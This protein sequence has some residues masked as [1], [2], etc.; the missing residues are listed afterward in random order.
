MATSSKSSVCSTRSGK[1]S[2][3]STSAARARARA[4]AAKVRA[5]YASQEAKL[6]M[7][8]ATREAQNQLETVRIDTE[9]EVLTL[10]R[11][12]DAAAVEA[13]VLEDAELAMHAAVERG[14]FESEK[15]KIECTSEYVNPQI[16]LQ[17]HSPSPVLS[18]LPVAPPFHADSHNSFITWSPAAKDTSHAQ[19]TKI[20]SKSEKADSMHLPATNLSD[21]SEG[22][23]KSEVGRT[24]PINNAPA[25]PY[26]AQY[27]PPASTP[28]QAEPLAQYLARR[29]LISSGLYQFDDKTENYR[30]WYSSFTSAAREVHLSATQE[31]D[32]MTKWLGKESGEMVKR[33]RS[34]H[35]SNPNLALH[36][37]W[38][39]LRECYAAPEV[40]ERSLFQR[41]DSFPRFSAKDHTKLRELRDLLMEIQG[42]KEDGYL[43]GLSYLDTSRGI[44]PVVDKLP[45]GLQDK[46]VTSG[47]WYKEGNY[48]RFPPFEYFCNFVC[49]EAKKRNYPSFMHQSSA[50]T[51][52]K[53]D[54]PIVKRFQTNKPISVH[55]TDVCA[56][57]DD[58]NKICPLHNKPH[59]LKKCRTFK[60]KL[61]DDRK[62]FLKEKG[63]C[64]KCCSSVSHLAKECKS[65]V[66]CSECGS[67]YHDAAMHP[68]PS[69]QVVKAPAPSQ[70]DGGEGEDHYNMAVVNTSCTEVCGPGQWGRSCSKICLVK[71][72]PK[73]SKDMAIKAY[74]IL[75]DQSNCSL[76][77]PEFF[78]L[79]NVESE[80]FSYH[81]RTC[82]GIIET[83]GKKAEG[84][85][86]ESLDGK[87]L[88]S[89]PPLI[90]CHEIMN[91][92]SEIP[93]P[94]A[95][96]Y[97][98]HLR[99]I[100]KH[101]PEL[102]PEAE[103]LLLLGRDVIR[104]HKVRQQVSGPI[105]APFAQ[106]MDLGWV[107]IGEVCLGNVHRP[108]VNTFKTNMLESGRHSIFL[109]CTS[110]MQVKETNKVVAH[111]PKQ[112]RRRLD[113]RC[114]AELSMTTNLLHP[115]KTQLS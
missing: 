26:I 102:E 97:Q 34:V 94:S 68:G 5:A 27:L 69:P 49:C 37:A 67:T 73:G 74:V 16:N 11:E 47:S 111:L 98:P 7:E 99:H 22:V 10:Q 40:I 76:A 41:L 84:F 28:P 63:I 48:G 46:W 29:D 60:N 20:K 14:G 92:R 91:N 13:Q 31:L 56:A 19:S 103:I 61:L 53:P 62:A 65:S 57:S 23:I 42:A 81:L 89:L 114:S 110:F 79:F 9:L 109:P 44:A 85:Q 87:V 2:A 77:R 70:E 108:T 54:R 39:R 6:K 50:T 33:I 78:E 71:L 104:A 64:F 24:S 45:Y 72:Y 8:K 21:L 107:V 112:L 106:R 93:T 96:L 66:K 1:S 25:K 80:Q 4:E 90:E 52:A 115:W 55:K 105:N 35:V 30:S 95:V 83:S 51:T 15:V 58:P 36:K 3:S 88:I 113:R 18:A 100:A 82:S 12:A 43:T 75:D 101:I 86:I 17:N 38:E 32:L 59:P